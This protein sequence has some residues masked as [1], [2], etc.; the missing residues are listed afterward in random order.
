M[1]TV[2]SVSSPWVILVSLV[3][4]GA[5]AASSVPFWETAVV[6]P[7]TFWPM[8][9]DDVS[10]ASVFSL[11]FYLF[12]VCILFL[13]E[14]LLC[15]VCM[16]SERLLSHLSSTQHVLVQPSQRYGSD[17]MKTGHI[18]Y[19]RSALCRTPSGVGRPR[20]YGWLAVRKS[21]V[22]SPSTAC[23]RILRAF[24]IKPLP[25]RS[26]CSSSQ[27]FLPSSKC[28]RPRGGIQ[29][30]SRAVFFVICLWRVN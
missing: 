27:S 15:W 25:L 14:R 11:V 7:T 9:L 22:A 30:E 26:S 10:S 1:S 23:F 29:R 13:P 21:G 5:A 4:S 8:N 16:F 28:V 24:S 2:N 17:Q 20:I 19:Y 3:T 18:F 12:V 6:T